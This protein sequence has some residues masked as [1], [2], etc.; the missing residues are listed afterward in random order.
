LHFDRLSRRFAQVP[1]KNP[2]PATRGRVGQLGGGKNPGVT[3]SAREAT[4]S[5]RG[6]R[7]PSII[8]SAAGLAK[9]RPDIGVRG[10]YAATTMPDWAD[11]VRSCGALRDANIEMAG[12]LS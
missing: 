5:W 4:R 12:K 6:V 11:S 2:P 10:K 7:S 1:A 9:S 3:R 8:N